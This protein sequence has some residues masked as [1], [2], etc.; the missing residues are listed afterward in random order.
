MYIRGY[1][2][3]T[4]F[5]YCCILLMHQHQYAANH[6]IADFLKKCQNDCWKWSLEVNTEHSKV[7][8]LKPSFIWCCTILQHLYQYAANSNVYHKMLVIQQKKLR[9]DICNKMHF[10]HF[11]FYCTIY[12]HSRVCSKKFIASCH[13]PCIASLL[14]HFLVWYSRPSL[15][16]F[17]WS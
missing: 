4:F 16:Y 2:F 10:I 14:L 7:D 3:C 6:E 17:P 5:I 13:P 9:I 12:Q 11:F 8:W 1:M 15:H